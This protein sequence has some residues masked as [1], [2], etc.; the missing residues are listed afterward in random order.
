MLQGID[1]PITKFS[2]ASKR[3]QQIQSI[4]KVSNLFDDLMTAIFL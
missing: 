4:L 2:K 3:S 1:L